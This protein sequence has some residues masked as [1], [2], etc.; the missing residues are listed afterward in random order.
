MDERYQYVAV[1]DWFHPALPEHSVSESGVFFFS[2][3][4]FLPLFSLPSL[5]CS[6][7]SACI[8]RAFL[9]SHQQQLFLFR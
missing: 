5:V 1:G 4:L 3:F 7:S 6:F 9:P 8:R 2:A